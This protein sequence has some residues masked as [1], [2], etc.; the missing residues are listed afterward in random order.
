MAYNRFE[1]SDLPQVYDRDNLP[2]VYDRD[3]LPQVCQGQRFEDGLQI[4]EPGSPGTEAA[5][6]DAG[7]GGKRARTILD[8][9]EDLDYS[10]SSS[11][12]WYWSYRRHRGWRCCQSKRDKQR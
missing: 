2:Q 11:A 10:R 5:I 4:L 9:E 12:D 7:S 6:I 8:E 3:S 1:G